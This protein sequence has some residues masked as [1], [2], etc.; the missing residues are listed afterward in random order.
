MPD[1][2]NQILAAVQLSRVGRVCL[3]SAHLAVE[4]CFRICIG[5]GHFR[6]AVV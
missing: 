2:A 6:Q 4:G 1:A 3:V 5:V